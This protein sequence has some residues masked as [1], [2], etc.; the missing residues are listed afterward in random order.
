[1][2]KEITI[3]IPAYN[4]EKRIKKTL[5]SYSQHFKGRALMLVSLNGCKDNTLGVVREVQKQWPEDVDYIDTKAAIGK[6]GAV[7][8]GFKTDIKTEYTGFVD[9]DG[10]TSAKEY[11]RLWR[12]IKGYDGVIASR[13][14]KGAKVHGRDS[15]KRQ[16]ASKVFHILVK[17]IFWM[18]FH[19]T[20]TGAKIF[21]TQVVK[22][23]LPKLGLI[24]NML[25]DVDLLYILNRN[26]Y[27]LKDEKTAA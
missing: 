23:I 4:E 12:L 8:K 6:G 17:M 20:Q 7:I 22:D 24:T 14:I 25:F 1:M 11:D 18:P 9:A 26:E 3:I 5:E 15:A 21:K 27:Q 10:A 2:K 13:W 16:F 19:D